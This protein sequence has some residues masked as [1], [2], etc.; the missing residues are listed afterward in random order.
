[1]KALFGLL[2]VAAAG[3]LAFAFMPP[4]F[5]KYQFSDDV[6][7][8]ARFSGPSTKTEDDI[9]QEVLNKAKGYEIPIK[10]EQVQVFREGQSVRIRAHYTYVVNLV[11]GKQVPLEFDVQSDK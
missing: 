7:S 8:I 3:Y 11:N 4:Y 1:M 6:T 9:R 2:V 10:P 5:S